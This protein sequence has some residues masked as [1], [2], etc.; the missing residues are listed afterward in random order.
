MSARR[1]LIVHGNGRG[2]GL[3]HL[4]LE[5]ISAAIASRGLE[6]RVHDLLA[7]GFDPVLRL[8]ADQS[9]AEALSAQQ[10]PLVARYQLDVGWADSFVIVHPVWWFAP[11]A[12][13]KGWVDRVLVD[14]I[15][16]SHASE[17]PRGLLAGRSALVVQTFKAPRLVDRILMGR[18]ASRFWSKAVFFSLG[19]K[20]VTPLALYEVGALDPERLQRFRERLERA[21]ETCLGQAAAR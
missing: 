11:P 17:P 5:Q 19:V 14:G 2:T 16:L 10:D 8:R 20:Q 18:L 12:I 1:V 6:L 21:L 4:L 13:L 7:D 9:H 15:A 3:C